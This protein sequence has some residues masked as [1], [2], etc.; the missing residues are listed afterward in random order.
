MIQ[1]RNNSQS[2][3]RPGKCW[4][5]RQ[6]LKRGFDTLRPCDACNPDEA[7]TSIAARTACATKFDLLAA[8]AAWGKF[9]VTLRAAYKGDRAQMQAAH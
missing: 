6:C 5:I 7:N 8:P 3:E 1:H 4:R 9:C 2:S